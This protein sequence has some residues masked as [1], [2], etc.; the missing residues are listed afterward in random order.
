[1]EITRRIRFYFKLVVVSALFICTALACGSRQATDSPKPLYTEFQ[2]M[3]G[4][5]IP[6]SGG[7]E[8]ILSVLRNGSCEYNTLRSKYRMVIDSETAKSLFDYAKVLISNSKVTDYSFLPDSTIAT[9]RLGDGVS[10]KQVHFYATESLENMYPMYR[11]PPEFKALET[12]LR[13]LLR[14]NGV[15]ESDIYS[16]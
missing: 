16:R 5:G 3:V 11:R 7:F 1:M 6:K 12:T 4:G 10:F 8:N 9:V 2:Y 15:K 14:Q 13:E